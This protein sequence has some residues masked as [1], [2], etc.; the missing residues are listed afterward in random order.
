[1]I[2]QRYSPRWT[3]RKFD[4]D[5]CYLEQTVPIDIASGILPI[6][7]KNRK[8][9]TIKSMVNGLKNPLID[10]EKLLDELLKDEGL[11]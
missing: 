5:V 7:T 4:G 6:H 1:M 2:C 11:W 10:K 3:F 9:N 8:I